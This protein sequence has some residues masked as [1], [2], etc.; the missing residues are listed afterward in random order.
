MRTSRVVFRKA[1]GQSDWWL[2][3]VNKWG[4]PQ[5]EVPFWVSPEQGFLYLGG[6]CWPPIYGNYHIVVLKNMLVLC[7]CTI[8][9]VLVEGT[10][11]R[12]Q[13]DIVLFWA[14]VVCV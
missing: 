3:G 10:A 2:V 11:T 9:I 14:P 7:S 12:P 5:I 4:F 1:C 6:L 13:D 8:C